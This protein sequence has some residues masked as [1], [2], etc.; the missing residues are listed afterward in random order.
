MHPTSTQSNTEVGVMAYVSNLT[1]YFTVG[2]IGVCQV[3]FIFPDSCVMQ[4]DECCFGESIMRRLSG[5]FYHMCV[6]FGHVHAPTGLELFPL[7]F[8]ESL[9]PLELHRFNTIQILT[10]TTL[11][12]APHAQ[13]AVGLCVASMKS[14]ARCLAGTLVERQAPICDLI[15][16]FFDLAST[17]GS[18][19]GG[20]VRY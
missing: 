15:L 19:V 20:P 16:G 8:T 9:C 12:T 11:F 2:R 1:S 4:S 3:T 6:L 10:H 7:S 18:T 14:C 5:I 13:R 17:N